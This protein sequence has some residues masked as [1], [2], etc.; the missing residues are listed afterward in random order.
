MLCAIC[1]INLRGS[2][3]ITPCK[4]VFHVNCLKRITHPCCPLCRKDIKNF[5]LKIGLTKK[6]IQKRLRE[7]EE[8][9]IQ[10]V[11]DTD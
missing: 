5:L 4:H 7:D 2:R 11:D 3:I 6:E 1:L 10:E 9:I 8:R